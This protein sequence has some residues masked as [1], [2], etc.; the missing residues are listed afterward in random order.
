VR[1]ASRQWS[2]SDEEKGTKRNG[3]ALGRLNARAFFSSTHESGRHGLAT[4]MNHGLIYSCRYLYN[5][6]TISEGRHVTLSQRLAYEC[7]KLFARREKAVTTG[8]PEGRKMPQ[9]VAKKGQ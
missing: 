7:H 8:L 2:F 6:V 1:I 5:T 9:L 4:I 3:R